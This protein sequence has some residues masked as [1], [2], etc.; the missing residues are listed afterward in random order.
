MM[1]YM[2]NNYEKTTINKLTYGQLF[3]YRGC[4]YAK[5]NYNTG[6]QEQ[7]GYYQHQVGFSPMTKVYASRG[8][9]H[10]NLPQKPLSRRTPT[11][12]SAA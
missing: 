12:W 5:G 10:G 3:H 4:W 1:S 11:G 2:S 9:Y 8:F 7:E 6:W